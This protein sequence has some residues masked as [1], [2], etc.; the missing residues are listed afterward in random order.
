MEIPLSEL[1]KPGEILCYDYRSKGSNPELSPSKKL[2]MLQWNIERGYELPSII[3]IL[4][5]VDADILALQE[6]DIGCARRYLGNLLPF[7]KMLNM[8]QVAM[9]IPLS[10]SREN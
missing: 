7:F 3:E 10:R 9:L 5:H 8:D 2:K 6:L 4:R 1:P